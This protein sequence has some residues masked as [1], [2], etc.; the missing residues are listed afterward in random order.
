MMMI[1]MISRL[2]WMWQDYGHV[3]SEGK[4]R[5]SQDESLLM[6][7]NNVIISHTAA[8]RSHNYLFLWLSFFGTGRL[9]SMRCLLSLAGN[10]FS[11]SL[12][13]AFN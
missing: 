3:E 4:I 11:F 9:R 7:V 12:I 5:P 8:C 6:H 10:D 1:M 2:D 13:A